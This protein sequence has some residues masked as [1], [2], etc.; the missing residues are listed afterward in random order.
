MKPGA[1]IYCRVSTKEQVENLSLPT[2][3]KRCRDYCQQ[4]NLDVFRVFHEKG[5]SA[6]TAD[7]PI[8]VQLLAYC[9]ENRKRLGH[10]IVNSVDRLSR[11]NYDYSVIKNLLNGLGI[12]VRSVNEGF[13]DSTEGKF[14]EGLNVLLAELDNNR[15]AD[16]TILG[17]KAAIENGTW[18]FAVPLGL[19]KEHK[20]DGSIQIVYDPE[21]AHLIKH[22]FEVYAEGTRTKAQ[23]LRSVTNLGLRTKTGRPLI[24]ETVDQILRR[25][26]YAGR[27]E[28]QN[29]KI[30][31]V[32]RFEPIVPMELFER[33][34]RRLAG[35]AVTPTKY[36]RRNPR[37]PL[38]QFAK[39]D[40]CKRPLAGSDSTGQ[41]K[42]RFSYYSCPSKGCGTRVRAE[43]LENLFEGQLQQVQPRAE[44]LRLFQAILLD[45]WEER[46]RTAFDQ[47]RI[48][49]ER[50]RFLKQREKVLRERYLYEKAVTRDLF[51][52]E[53]Q[54]LRRQIALAEME[55]H[56]L[57]LEEL[58]V[59]G[60][61]GFAEHMLGNL[62][63]MWRQAEADQKRRL[64][65]VLFPEGITFNGESIGTATMSSVFEMLRPEIIE[66][67]DLASP[68]RF[69]LVL[70][71]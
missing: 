4:K 6:K 51:D 62:P 44:Y 10:V 67:S 49:E 48:I 9:Q 28:V 24:A 17:M 42:K 18:P 2:Q 32:G 38:T 65:A 47:R 21:R 15:K 46:N 23:I 71:P 36:L 5:E 31:A 34:Q 54:E 61:L 41:S 1:V 52:D 3:E 26:I 64:Q 40:R 14:H 43:T 13:D 60:I 33:V 56:D 27:L 50:I 66:K 29:W 16:R 7:R 11:N 20:A 12:S 8:L 25:P 68:T 69:E 37:F 39:C 58:D 19:L 63:K 45:V 55:A 57:D 59:R 53:D 35:R 30:A 22:I 70:P